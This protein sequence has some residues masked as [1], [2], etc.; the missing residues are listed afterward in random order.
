MCEPSIIHSVKNLARPTPPSASG[1]A[2]K[3]PRQDLWRI[4]VLIAALSIAAW[5]FLGGSVAATILLAWIILAM[6]S[7]GLGSVDDPYGRLNQHAPS[8]QQ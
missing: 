1:T 2:T 3:A 4:L 5:G 7:R 6:V 8:S